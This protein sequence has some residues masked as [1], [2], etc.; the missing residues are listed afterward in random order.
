MRACPNPKC[1]AFA[2]IVYSLA[3]RCPLCKWDLKSVLPV[4]EIP[5]APKPDRRGNTRQQSLARGA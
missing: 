1:S 4:S 5:D 2:R 3:T